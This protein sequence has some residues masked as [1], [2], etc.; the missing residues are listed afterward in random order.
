M[1]TYISQPS[2]SRVISV[3]CESVR[4]SIRPWRETNN[5]ENLITSV[6]DSRGHTTINISGHNN[7]NQCIWIWKSWIYWFITYRIQGHTLIVRIIY[8]GSFE[9]VFDFVIFNTLLLHCIV[10]LYD[11]CNVY[12][13]LMI[14]CFLVCVVR[15]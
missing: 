12:D 9:I 5:F 4:C 7:K 14:C 10:T 15:E 11:T 2:N 6:E 1:C 8:I 3:D 13:Y